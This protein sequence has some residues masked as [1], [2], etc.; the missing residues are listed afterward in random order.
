MSGVFWDPLG[1]SIGLPCRVSSGIVDCRQTIWRS[2][3]LS[4]LI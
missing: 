4:A 2:L 1:G 3:T